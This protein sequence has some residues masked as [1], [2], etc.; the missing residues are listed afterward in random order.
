MC[1]FFTNAL[2]VAHALDSISAFVMC[3]E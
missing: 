2:D 3:V 1:F